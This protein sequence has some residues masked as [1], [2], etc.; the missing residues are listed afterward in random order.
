M[1]RSVTDREWS[2]RPIEWVDWFPN[3]RVY[4]SFSASP[5]L[6]FAFFPFYFTVYPVPPCLVFHL[7]T[8]LNVW[9]PCQPDTLTRVSEWMARLVG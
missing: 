8:I 3:G 1:K 9:P 7:S 2:C 6:S 4:P 5:S